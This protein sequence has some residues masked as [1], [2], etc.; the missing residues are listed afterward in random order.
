M[1]NAPR[2]FGLYIALAVVLVAGLVTLLVMGPRWLTTPAE[3][4]EP[5]AAPAAEAR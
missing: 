4:E 5:V 3:D 2:G 1:K